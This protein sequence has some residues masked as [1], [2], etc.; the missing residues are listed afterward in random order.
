MLDEI[1]DDYE[2]ELDNFAN[3][4]DKI[5][6]PITIL[7]LGCLVGFLVYAIYAP[8]FNLGKVMLPGEDEDKPAA[9]SN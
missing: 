6:E 8:I 5:L 1:A 3:Q 4:I 2:E 7:F 9:T